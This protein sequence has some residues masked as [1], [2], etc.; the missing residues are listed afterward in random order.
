MSAE[1]VARIGLRGLEKKQRE[2]IPGFL[3]WLTSKLVQFA[4]RTPIEILSGKFF[5]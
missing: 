3:N 5:R 2:V 1:T 4:P